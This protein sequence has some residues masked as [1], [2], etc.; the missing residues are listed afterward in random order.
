MQNTSSERDRER[1]RER[2]CERDR[3]REQERDREREREKGGPVGN[4]EH[5][6]IWRPGV[7]QIVFTF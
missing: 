7:K 5:A 4:V 1:D 6:P 3:E 2:E